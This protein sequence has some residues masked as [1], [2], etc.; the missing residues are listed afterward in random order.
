MNKQ[1]AKNILT[2]VKERA[3]EASGPGKLKIALVIQGGTLRSVASCGS[4]AALNYLNLTNAF[5]IVY[6]ASSGA[7]NAAYFLSNQGALGITVY[8]EDVNNRRFI[9]FL[10]FQKIMDLEY[11]FEEIVLKRK[12]HDSD[13]LIKHPTELQVIT[14]DLDTSETVWFSSKDSRIDFYAAMKASCALPLIY[15]RGVLVD[16]R[17]FIDGFIKEPIPIITPFEKDYTDILVLMTRNISFRESSRVGLFSKL[18]FD[19]L[20][21]RE[22]KSDLYNL[23][24]GRSK[25]YNWAA[26]KINSGVYRRQDGHE[27]RI[28]YICPDLESEAYKFELNSK[29]LANAAYS[30]WKNTFQFFEASEGSTRDD[31]ENELIK[32]KQEIGLI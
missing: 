14:T 4:A 20:M 13:K 26:D 29:R 2:R 23:Y 6:A 27:I 5:D 7:V 15:G 30:S 11:F 16:G 32:A 17:R 12:K 8:T 9:N 31:F 19:P 3:Q 24:K 25:L 10:R 28:A 1:V 21:K 22:I 18:I